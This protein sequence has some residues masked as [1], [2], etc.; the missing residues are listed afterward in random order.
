MNRRR[1]INI[2]L[3]G[4]NL[5]AESL[6]KALN[7]QGFFVSGIIDKKYNDICL[8]ESV[9]KYGDII[10]A[11]LDNLTDFKNIDYANSLVII[12][13]NNGMIHERV[14][15]MLRTLHFKKIV[16]LPTDNKISIFDQ[17]IMRNLFSDIVLEHNFSSVYKV[18]SFLPNNFPLM[19][20]RR[21]AKYTSL[22]FPVSLL[23]TND[24]YEDPRFKVF[25]DKRITEFFPYFELFDYLECAKLHKYP[26]SYLDIFTNYGTEDDKRKLLA[27][28]VSLFHLYEHNFISN[29]PFFL[30]SP[31]LIDI[32]KDGK[33]YVIDGYHRC[34][35][36]Y[37]KGLKFIPVRINNLKLNLLSNF[38][39]HN[40]D[41]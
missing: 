15:E 27:D 2:F 8:D 11:S 32:R 22:L 9:K 6:F 35:Y 4:D 10:F 33:P 16:Y 7:E 41:K 12:C 1:K 5:I 38:Y 21:T 29:F 28:R 23:F 36:L 37:K 20:I 13:L 39:E 17:E 31:A 30:F 3:Y 26:S 40:K 24:L 18:P 25:E 14:A 34:I 19:V